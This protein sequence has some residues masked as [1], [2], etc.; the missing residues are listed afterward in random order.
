[1]CYLPSLAIPG[2]LSLHLFGFEAI[3]CISCAMS[4]G[5]SKG[6]GILHGSQVWVCTDMGTGNDSPTRDLQN[7]S[8]NIIFGPELSELQLIS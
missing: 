6:W 5:N 3:L 1:M 7:E 2:L 8:K 4:I